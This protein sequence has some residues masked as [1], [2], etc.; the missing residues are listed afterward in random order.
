MYRGTFREMNKTVVFQAANVVAF[1]V[2]VVV[3]GL[4]GSTT[5][6]GGVTSAEICDM[7]QH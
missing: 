1:I 4:A 5:V 6:L 2:M 7:S 3:N